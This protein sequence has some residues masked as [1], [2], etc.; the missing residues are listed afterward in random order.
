MERYVVENIIRP[1][2]QPIEQLS[3]MDVSTVYEAQGKKG[4]M[5]PLLR[6]VSQGN[7]IC[8]PAVTAVCYAGDNLMI[9]AAIEVCRPG[10]ILV[11]ATIGDSDAGMIGE[12]IV[13][14]LIKRGVKGLIIDAGIRD[15]ARI[16]SLGFPVWSKSIHSEGTSKNKGGWVNKEAVVGGT[17]IRPGDAVMADDDGIVVIE[18]SDIPQT[19]AFSK[20][21]LAKEEK[22]KEK[23]AQ[24]EISLDFYSLRSVLEEEKVSYYSNE[25]EINKDRSGRNDD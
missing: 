16:R 1:N 8:G 7:L 22:V 15:V 5:N 3:K 4:L 25:E 21:R 24:G 17:N 18:Q 20:K 10:D 19:I 9:H 6:P 12:L 2:N 23:I 14:A 11:V 13:H